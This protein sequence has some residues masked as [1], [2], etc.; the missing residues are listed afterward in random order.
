MVGL[1]WLGLIGW[2]KEGRK[3]GIDSMEDVTKIYITLSLLVLLY[4]G[5]ECRSILWMDGSLALL[6]RE[7]CPTR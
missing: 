4:F 7:K 6:E 5:K 1:A 2:T 3:E